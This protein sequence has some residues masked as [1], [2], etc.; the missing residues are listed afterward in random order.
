MLHFLPSPIIAIINALALCLNTLF[1]AV[2][3][4]VTVIARLLIPVK[5]WQQACSKTAVFI[6]ENWIGVNSFMFDLTH[7][8]EWQVSWPE[9]LK[10]DEWYM[11]VSNHQSWTDI[12][13][14]QYLF[15]R[16][17][18]FLKFFIKHDLIYVPVIGLAWWG[19][20]FPFM[21]RYSKKML[22][23]KPHLKGKDLETTKK[24][25]AKF[26][27]SPVAIMN[28]LEGTRFTPEKHQR[29]GSEYGRLLKPKSGGIAFALAALDHRMQKMI[30]VTIAYPDGHYQF[31]DFFSGKT[32]T[33]AVDI[34][35]REIPQHILQGDYANDPQFKTQFQAYVT[36]LW[37]EKDLLLEKLTA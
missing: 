36:E 23:K 37:Q 30:D 13:V 6:A 17:I 4:Y 19:L 1:W 26:K 15:N 2:P 31:W 22:E 28:F 12:F 7:Q 10:M 20:E 11:V 21:K 29:Q 35:E 25:C 5:S 9:S 27:D 32:K 8:T 24:A 34:Q 3:L 14:L 18:P 16:K 33:I